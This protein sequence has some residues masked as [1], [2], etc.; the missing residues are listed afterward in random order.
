MIDPLKPLGAFIENTIRPLLG[1]FKWFFE[2]CE[3]KGL[4]L[5]E[6]NITRICRV[7]GNCHFRTVVIQMCQAVLITIILC[8]TWIISQS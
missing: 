1:E 8:V 7:I 5:N 6:E 3:K 2:E 4:N